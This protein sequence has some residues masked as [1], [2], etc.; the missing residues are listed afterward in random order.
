MFVE[1]ITSPSVSPSSYD[2]DVTATTNAAIPSAKEPDAVKMIPNVPTKPRS[3]RLDD[4]DL[5]IL[6]RLQ[7]MMRRSQTEVISTA[8]VHLM[9]TVQRDEPVRVTLPEGDDQ[10]T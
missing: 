7:R 4:T 8:L 10:I 9:A 3:F 1:G 6:M 2:G 5:E